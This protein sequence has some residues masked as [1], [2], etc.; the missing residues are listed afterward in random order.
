MIILYIIMYFKQREGSKDGK[1]KR[2]LEGEEEVN[3]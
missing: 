3:I 2:Y 1:S